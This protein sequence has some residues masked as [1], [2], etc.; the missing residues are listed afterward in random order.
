MDAAVWAFAMLVIALSTFARPTL[1]I[2]LDSKHSVTLNEGF[3]GAFLNN[4][5]HIR[6][7]FPKVY[8][9]S[10]VFYQTTKRSVSA[11]IPITTNWLVVNFNWKTKEQ[12]G[13]GFFSLLRLQFSQSVPTI[14]LLHV[15]R[16]PKC[17]KCE[18]LVVTYCGRWLLKK[19]RPH[20]E[21][22]ACSYNRGVSSMSLFQ[23]TSRHRH[24]S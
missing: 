9:S 21:S 14:V 7:M 17:P 11:L 8:A 24:L 6:P 4:W 23:E 15:R 5:A 18:A 20:W 10:K 1:A 19:I 16:H 12:L 2:K 3:L 13:Y 22:L